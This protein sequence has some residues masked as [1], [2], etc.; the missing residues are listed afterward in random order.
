MSM[1]LPAGGNRGPIWG[2]AGSGLSSLPG[3]VRLLTKH[4]Q[5]T[6][7]LAKNITVPITKIKQQTKQNNL[8]NYL[9]LLTKQLIM[10]KNSQLKLEINFE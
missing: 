5:N 7:N 4:M 9:L 1:Y 10:S 3:L 6:Q 8:Q 2:T